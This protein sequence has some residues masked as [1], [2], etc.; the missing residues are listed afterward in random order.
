ME[1]LVTIDTIINWLTKQVQE[2]NPVGPDVWLD[3]AQKITVL[4]QEEQEKLFTLEQEVAR[5]RN[6][7]L[8]S[9]ESVA[10]AK[11]RIEATEEYKNA[12]RQKAKI[13]KCLELVR[14]AKL[15]SRMASEVLRGS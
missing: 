5:L 2:K 3:A 6:L 1:D 11:S 9:D 13:E 8:D 10:H 7:L 14:I 15:Q 4:L 12:R